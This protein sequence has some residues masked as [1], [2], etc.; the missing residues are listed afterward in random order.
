MGK[1][2]KYS[3]FNFGSP[4]DAKARL[5]QQFHSLATMPSAYK[6]SNIST[7]SERKRIKANLLGPKLVNMC[8]E[9]NFF[10]KHGRCAPV[11]ADFRVRLCGKAAH[12]VTCS[13]IRS[14]PSLQQCHCVEER[15]R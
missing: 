12:T 9:L 10:K 8:Y 15:T 3:L 14:V 6:E 5:I 4:V 13:A 1:V 11:L 7:G 2:I